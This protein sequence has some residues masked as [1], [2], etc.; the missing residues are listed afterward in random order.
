MTKLTSILLQLLTIHNQLYLIN[1]KKSGFAVP[2]PIT[3]NAD[4]FVIESNSLSH[5]NVLGND[6]GDGAL[7]IQQATEP[8]HGYLAVLDGNVQVLY[9]PDTDF[10]GLDCKL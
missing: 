8:Q 4:S 2:S 6:S 9:A 1:G 10:V 5:F 3:A 7:Y